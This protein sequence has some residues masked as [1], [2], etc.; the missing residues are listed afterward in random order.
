MH[1]FM[2]NW[3]REH[4]LIN[5]DGDERRH[6][7][8]VWQSLFGQLNEHGRKSL[9]LDF[10]TPSK[11]QIKLHWNQLLL[12]PQSDAINDP[13]FAHILMGGQFGWLDFHL[14]RALAKRLPYA[15]RALDLRPI[16]GAVIG[17][18]LGMAMIFG[19]DRHFAEPPFEPAQWQVTVHYQFAAKPLAIALQ[20]HLQ[21]DQFQVA[22]PNEMSDAAIKSNTILY[23]PGGNKA[24][25]RIKHRLG[26]LAYGA[27]VIPEESLALD[28]LTIQV[29]LADLHGAAFRDPL[30]IRLPFEPEMVVIPPGK[31]LMGSPENEEGRWNAE[32]PQ[33][34]VKIDYNFEIGKYEVTFDEYDAF[35]NA[36]KRQLP[37]DEGWRRGKRPVINVTWNDAQAY[38]Q[39]LSEQTGKQ[40]RLPTEAE[41]EYAARAG[42]QTRYWWGDDIG[43]NSA[44]CDGC[45][46][47]WDNK[48]TAPAGSFKPNTFG[49]YDTAGNVWEWTQDC[50]H[51]NYNNAPG[52]G[53]AW[54]EKDEGDCNRRVV[55]GGSWDD[56]P[57]NLR[58]ADRDRDYIGGAFNNLGFRIAG[59][60]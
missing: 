17:A 18:M 59:D 13:I 22:Q 21:Q 48:Q 35:A 10:S 27:D 6:V 9:Q 53:S 11:R 49:L 14:P 43:Q 2:P 7:V 15:Q 40:Y 20:Q 42:T 23:P 58:S 56:R 34:E 52:N 33:R 24:A 60:F 38:T 4:L 12:M 32:G 50:W 28:A 30:N 19:I 54:L 47:Q 1:G 44:A 36:T 3:L 51:E 57:R 25:A 41:W 45:G 26:L 55:R 16:L 37:K 29:Q 39:W 5:S 31:F 8:A 46:S